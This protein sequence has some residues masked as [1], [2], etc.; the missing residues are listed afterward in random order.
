MIRVAIPFAVAW[1]VLT[2]VLFVLWFVGWQV[3]PP[4]AEFTDPAAAAERGFCLP[5]WHLWF[6][7]YLVLM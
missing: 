6:L 3:T 4:P 2:P 1:G 5:T 7:Q